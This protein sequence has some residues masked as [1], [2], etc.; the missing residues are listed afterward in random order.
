MIFIAVRY[1]LERRRQTFFTFLGVFFGTLAYVAVSGFFLGFQGFMVEQLVNNQAQVHIQSRESSVGEH[2]L[3]VPFFG[4]GVAHVFWE[5]PPASTSGYLGV[6]NP[7]GWYQRL[8]ADP[9]VTA[10]A[11][12]INAPAVL[13]LAKLSVSS[14]IVGC[15]PEQQRLVTGVA[16]YMTDGQFTDIAAGGNRLILG[17]E[18]MRRL[19]AAVNQTVLV[20]AG[21][22]NP[23]PFKIVGRFST[24]IRGFDMQAYGNLADVQRLNGT[25]NR[26]TE[27][28]VRLRDYS[29]ARAMSTSWSQIAPELIESWDQQNE[30]VLSMFVIQDTLRFTM[31]LTVIVVASFGIYN[32]LNITVN[33]K[34]QD[35]AI[36]RSMGY[37]TFDVVMLFFSQGFLLGIFGGLAGLLCGYWVCRYLQTIP[38]A[39]GP[40]GGEGHLHIAITFATYGQAFGLAL[41]SASVAS[42]LP[43]RA[44]GKLTPIDIIRS[45][46]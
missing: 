11:P 12:T 34:R 21:K 15:L 39:G 18:V 43:A 9:R 40:M 17:A 32:V 42:I 35:I 7:Q 28:G 2:E 10:Y 16:G 14:S 26:V 1:L 36:L 19:G 27:I 41:L 25:P 6:Q 3:D 22:K 33:Q 13:T 31:I 4:D 45:G 37:D 29:L 8:A 46:G 20:S 30:N 5:V 24:G 44:A 23:I 38:F